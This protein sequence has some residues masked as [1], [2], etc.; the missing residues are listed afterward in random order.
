MYQQ[1][2]KADVDKVLHQFKHT[3]HRVECTW[4]R[5]VSRWVKVSLWRARQQ[6]SWDILVLLR[7]ITL[8][9]KTWLLFALFKSQYS[10]WGQTH[11]AWSHHKFG[12]KKETF[13]F[14]DLFC[15]HHPRLFK[16]THRLFLSSYVN[17]TDVNECELDY[18]DCHTDADCTNTEGA[19]TCACKSGYEGDGNTCLGEC[20][21]TDLFITKFVRITMRR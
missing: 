1:N 21:I 3:A 14:A 10:W 7:T 4:Y 9:G 11:F 2:A 15:N 17:N 18:D 16:T 6:G 8:T 13:G 12:W 19:F 20:P 5:I